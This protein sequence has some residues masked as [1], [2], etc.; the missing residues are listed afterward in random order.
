MPV[1]KSKAMIAT[2]D[3]ALVTIEVT[4]NGVTTEF[5]FDTSNKVQ[6]EP[7]IEEQEA[8]KLIIKGV[9]R[10][11]KPAET[12]ITGHQ[13]TLI[14]NVF[15]PELVQILQGG[16]IL[17]D[18]E[19]E[20][21]VVGYIPPVAGSKEKG[22]VFKLNIYSAQYDVSGQIVRY[23]KTSYP[24]CVGT[25]VAFSV[26]DGVF[27]VSE[28]IINSAPGTGEAPYEISYVNELPTLVDTLVD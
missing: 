5:G 17:Y 19:D 15:N 8:V 9:L 21:N 25:P 23:E 27:R 6:V 11:Q 24:N 12:T 1:K 22:K 4:E 16:T 20:D 3:C 26:E 2:I 10:A 28:Y 13:I 14:D 18:E 7:Q